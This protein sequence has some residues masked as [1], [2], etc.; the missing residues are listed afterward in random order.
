MNIGQ[1]I[2]AERERRGLSLRALSLKCNSTSHTT[3]SRIEKGVHKPGY[4]TLQDISQALKIDVDV[5]IDSEKFSDKIVTLDR[6]TTACQNAG[7]DPKDIDQ[8]S[9]EQIDLAVAMFK[10]MLNNKK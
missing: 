7:L 1:K 8:M 3:I 4:D 2:K 9:Q 5:L 10:Q 6:L